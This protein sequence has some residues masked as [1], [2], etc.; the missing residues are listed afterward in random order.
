MR[1]LYVLLL[2]LPMQ[3][4]AIDKVFMTKAE[5][6]ILD[7]MRSSGRFMDQQKDEPKKVLKLDGVVFKSAGKPIV[8]VNGKNTIKSRKINSSVHVHTKNLSP[9]KPSVLVTKDKSSRYM[10]PGQVWEP[11]AGRVAEEYQFKAVK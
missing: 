11:S 10:K 9:E 4:Y 7:N 1:M 3:S 5:R 2:L 8:F 6:N